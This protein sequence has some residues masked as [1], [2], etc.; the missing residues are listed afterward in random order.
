[1]RVF[2]HYTHLIPNSIHP[3]VMAQLSLAFDAL[4][5]RGMKAFACIGSAGA[6]VK[7]TMKCSKLSSTDQAEVHINGRLTGCLGVT[8]GSRGCTAIKAEG[9]DWR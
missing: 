6:D 2:F 7:D 5:R 8:C 4:S 3:F 9:S 1:M